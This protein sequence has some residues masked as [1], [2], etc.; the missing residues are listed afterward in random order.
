MM[1][2]EVLRED[3]E[4]YELQGHRRQMLSP[5]FTSVGISCFEHAGRTICVMEF[6]YSNSG[7]PKTTADD[8]RKTVVI[9]YY[10]VDGH[11]IGVFC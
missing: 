10:C 9:P 2:L 11:S 1:A 6:G 5:D 3:D 4:W 7:A 8:S